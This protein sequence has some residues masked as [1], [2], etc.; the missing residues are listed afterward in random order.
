MSEAK[1][2]PKT[3]LAAIPSTAKSENFGSRTSNGSFGAPRVKCL[4]L[5]RL[6]RSY[7]FVI[8][9]SKGWIVRG[10]GLACAVRTLPAQHE[11]G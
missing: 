7:P 3:Q 4:R 6:R 10:G 1:N 9:G 8:S 11:R 2:E 5:A